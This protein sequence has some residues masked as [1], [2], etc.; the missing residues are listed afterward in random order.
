MPGT[1]SHSLTDT[2]FA[3]AGGHFAGE[4]AF[5]RQQLAESAVNRHRIGRNSAFRRVDLQ[6]VNIRVVFVSK[7]Q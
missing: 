5:I 2:H 3:G 7:H 4:N 1:S 6:V